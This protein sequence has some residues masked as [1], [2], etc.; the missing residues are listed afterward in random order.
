MDN[1][2]MRYE[3]HEL[4][5]PPDDG[6]AVIWRYID[7]TKLVAL[8]DSKSLFL[9]RADTLGDEFEGSYSRANVAL[10]PEIYK[11]IPAESLAMISGFSEAMR[12]HT[13]VNCWNM[14]QHESAALWGLYV[15]PHGGVALRSTFNRLVHCFPPTDADEPSTMGNVVHIGRVHYVDYANDWIP[16]GNTMWPF[17]HKRHSFE[18][19]SELRA[20]AQDPPTVEDPDAEGGT[21]IDLSQPSPEGKLVP[22]DLDTLVEAIYVSPVAPSWFSDLV[23]SVCAHY[24]LHKPVTPSGLAERPV[25]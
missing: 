2:S 19:E 11:E 7:F 23:V 1:V 8:L 12:R 17:V 24:G 6:D 16:E 9:A 13:F 14:A 21:R 3:E 18:F 15:P 22:V 10:R 4:F 20:V 5:S 25:Y